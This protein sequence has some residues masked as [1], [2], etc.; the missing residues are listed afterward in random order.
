MRLE[1]NIVIRRTPEDVWSF[2]SDPANISKWDRGVAG[3]EMRSSEPAPGAE[4]DTLAHPRHGQR[5]WGRMSYRVAETGI[6][7]SRV[8]LTSSEGNARFFKSAEWIFHTEPSDDGTLLTCAAEFT[9]RLQFLFL[10]PVFYA[11]KRAIHSDL[12]RLK[13]VLEGVPAS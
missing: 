3:V 6:N 13:R 1:S 12:E 10:A 4:F 5:D 9:L 11:M 7:T 8:Q 2:L